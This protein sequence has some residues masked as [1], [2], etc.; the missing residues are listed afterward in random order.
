MGRPEQ[1]SGRDPVEYGGVWSRDRVHFAAWRPS[2]LLRRNLPS[3]ERPYV[4][5]FGVVGAVLA[6]VISAVTLVVLFQNPD[7][8]KGVWGAAVWFGLGIA[9]FAL[10]CAEASGIVA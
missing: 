2:C 3:I 1:P 8:N 4:S 5:P 6:T 10:V 9:Y 7:Y